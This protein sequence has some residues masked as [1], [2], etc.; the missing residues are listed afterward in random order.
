MVVVPVAFWWA[1][2]RHDQELNPHSY[3]SP[4]WADDGRI[5]F[6]GYTYGHEMAG[7]TE[8][9][10]MPPGGRPERVRVTN[11]KCGDPDIVRL[12]P[13]GG[14]VGL[15]LWCR[16]DPV[17]PK[18]VRYRVAQ[19]EMQ[20]VTVLPRGP[21]ND[22]AWASNDAFGIAIADDLCQG[23]LTVLTPAAGGPQIA[24]D[25]GACLTH[26][27]TSAPRLALDNTRLVFMRNQ[28]CPSFGSPE[29]EQVNNEGEDWSLCVMV[30]A[31]GGSQQIV[32]GFSGFPKV[33]VDPGLR[34]AW[35]PAS[36][37]LS[38]A[39]G[40]STSGRTRS[41]GCPPETWPCPP[42]AVPWP[43]STMAT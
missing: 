32:S 43:T 29:A 12:F 27:L 37:A 34:R 10:R 15:L 36:I 1:G 6:L 30:L 18:L 20:V 19:E 4:V 35:C 21:V 40:W 11:P 42:T 23:G 28:G 33:N 13:I 39:S 17:G 9:L 16:N 26:G 38:T 22:P 14:D 7:P 41:P 5:Y 31:T 24:S 3:Q 8:L 25:Q 2:F